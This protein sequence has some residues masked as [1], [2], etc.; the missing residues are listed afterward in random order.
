M[1]KATL[2]LPPGSRFSGQQLGE[3]AAR[4]LGRADWLPRQAES[5]REQLQRY[6]QLIP[7]HWPV[8]ALTRQADVGDATGARWLRADPCHVRPDI[9]GARLMACGEALSLDEADS[10][11]LLPALKP[12]F[13]DSGF[14]ID[15]PTASRWYLRLP[16]EAKLPAFTDPA[17]ALGADLFEHLADGREGRRWRSLLGEAQVV[18]H[19]HPWNARRLERG[20]LPINSLWFWGAGILPDTIRCKQANVFSEDETL[21]ALA[22]IT[23]VLRPTPDRFQLHD[24]DSLFDLT[25]AR[26]LAQVDAEWLQ[27]AFVALLE[28]SLE[29]LQMD[30]EDGRQFVMK[31]S[32]RWR[33]WRRPMRD[34]NA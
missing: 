18:L 1:T 27:P 4:W 25:A 19:N 23:S 21:R 6:F 34:F 28:K 26:D 20:L 9:N 33:F 14:T 10:T 30:F 29:S 15:A 11:A 16:V 3:V 32:Q 12:V 13:G 22:S 17:D 5:R 2:L 31:A 7:N 24:G 8:A